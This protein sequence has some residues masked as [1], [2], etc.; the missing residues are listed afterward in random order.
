MMTKTPL[1]LPRSAYAL[2]LDPEQD[3][4]DRP[5]IPTLPALPKP[6]NE[7]PTLRRAPARP[8]TPAAFF[9]GCDAWE[10]RQP[11][12]DPK[13]EER[14]AEEANALW[15]IGE[16]RRWLSRWV[17]AAAMLCLGIVVLAALLAAHGK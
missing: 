2:E 10:E 15:W 11:P 4:H 6:P 1:S 7:K 8:V 16:R 3:M 17:F 9:A 12:S 13:L 14:L 5:T